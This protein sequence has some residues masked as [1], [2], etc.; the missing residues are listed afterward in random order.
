MTEQNADTAGVIAFPP[1]L[2][3]G[4]LGAAVLLQLI[5]P[6]GILAP[7]LSAAS[8]AIGVPLAVLAAVLA[9]SGIRAFRTA[10]TNVEPFKP[11]LVLVDAGPYRFTRNPMYLG[12]MLL[13][14][15]LT[16]LASLDWGLLTL[17]ALALLL[18]FGVVLREERYLARRFG[19]PYT[20]YLARTRR[21][22]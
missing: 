5:A 15:A 8:L 14:L 6:I 10:G 20:D 13:H 2:L 1:L 12:L 4:A 11:A 7:A 21:W 9:I 16:V 3:A 17:V 19:Q 22:L 18:H